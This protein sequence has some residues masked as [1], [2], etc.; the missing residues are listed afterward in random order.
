MMAI[1]EAP[2]MTKKWVRVCYLCYNDGKLREA[3]YFY[4]SKPLIPIPQT[5][6]FDVCDEHAI[7]CKKEGRTVSPI[8]DETEREE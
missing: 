4:V 1:L 2:K 6:T 8:M 3:T 7:I 5:K